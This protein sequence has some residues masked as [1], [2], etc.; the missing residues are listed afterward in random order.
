MLFQLLSGLGAILLGLGAI[1]LLMAAQANADA[2]DDRA[3]PQV[4]QIMDIDS[5]RIVAISQG[6][7]ASD[8][9]RSSLSI[10]ILGTPR[11]GS[12]VAQARVYFIASD[13]ELRNPRYSDRLGWIEMTM[14][15]ETLPGVL[16][17]LGEPHGFV[18]YREWSRHEREAE[19]NAGT[20]P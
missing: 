16:A 10:R 8:P 6:G 5:Y 13:A 2:P 9:V 17:T 20:V 18:R 7:I 4:L 3:T 12:Q 15:I 14:P 19:L 11:D 1:L